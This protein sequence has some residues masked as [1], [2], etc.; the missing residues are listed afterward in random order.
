[1]FKQCVLSMC[2]LAA[3]GFVSAQAADKAKPV[4]ASSASSDFFFKPYVGADYQ[5]SKYGNEDFGGAKSDDIIDTSLHGANIHVGARVHKNLGFEL[6][7]AQSQT[8]EKQNAAVVVAGLGTF[9][10]GKT[11]VQTKAFVADVLGYYSITPKTE[12][13]GTFGVSYTKAELSA[14]GLS[15]DE[16][17]WKPRIGTGAQYWFTDNL[18]ARGL[19][20]YQGANFDDSVD[21]AVTASLGLNYQF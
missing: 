3:S 11:E 5:Y 14:L 12:L 18:N 17:E 1:M 6:G 21:N 8:G 15:V 19:V 20:R 9:P 16:K 4:T 10:I 2:I 13:I 7:Y